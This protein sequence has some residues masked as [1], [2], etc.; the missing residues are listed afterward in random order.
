MLCWRSQED[1]FAWGT[2][3]WA[4]G[5]WFIGGTKRTNIESPR[6][7]NCFRLPGLLDLYPTFYSHSRSHSTRSPRDCSLPRHVGSIEVNFFGK[8]IFVERPGGS[9][10]INCPMENR[11]GIPVFGTEL[12]KVIVEVA[13]LAIT[14]LNGQ[15]LLA[16]I[17]GSLSSGKVAQFSALFLPKNVCKSKI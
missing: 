4:Y 16:A 15:T 14:S 7:D 1:H 11:N 5:W 3:A 12:G 8:S 2:Y 6:Q 13:A 9:D 10:W 17:Q